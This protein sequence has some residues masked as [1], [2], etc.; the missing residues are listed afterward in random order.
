MLDN[1]SN[2]SGSGNLKMLVNLYPNCSPTQQCVRVFYVPGTFCTGVEPRPCVY[3]I[4]TGKARLFSMYPY[5]C[6][7]FMFPVCHPVIHMGDACKEKEACL[8]KEGIIK[9]SIV[10][11]EKLYH[12]VLQFRANQK[13]IF[14][15]CRT[16]VLT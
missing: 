10:P 15:L 3:T 1:R 8:L 7:Y 6:K 2:F 16:C 4:R 9:C 14:N 12:P 13:L 5:I 11:P